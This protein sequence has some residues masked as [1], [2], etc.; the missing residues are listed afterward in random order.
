MN[1][2]LTTLLLALLLGTEAF[3]VSNSENMMKQ[4]FDTLEN[5]V[6]QHGIFHPA[7]AKDYKSI[8]KGY[9]AQNK[10]DEAT[11]YAL[12]ALKVELKLLSPNDPELAKHYFETGNLYYKHKAYP[13]AL[14]YMEKAAA[15]YAVADKESLPLADTYEAI[16]SIY[17]SLGDPQKALVFNDKARKIRKAKLPSGDAVLKRSEENTKFL[18]GEIEKEKK[19]AKQ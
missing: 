18:E 17:V 10:L 7:V 2:T 4:A 3:A 16:A 1:S 12:K 13:T 11:D 15:I 9:L 8:S 14:L 19:A 6:G 5:D